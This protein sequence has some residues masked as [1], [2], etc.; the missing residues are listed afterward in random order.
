MITPKQFLLL[1]ELESPLIDRILKAFSSDYGLVRKGNN[2]VFQSKK[3]S[4]TAEFY[5]LIKVHL[6]KILNLKMYKGD[7]FSNGDE[8]FKLVR[9]EHGY[10]LEF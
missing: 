5:E 10:K 6:T 7:E 8:T 3:K 2:L 4:V 1:T 9:I